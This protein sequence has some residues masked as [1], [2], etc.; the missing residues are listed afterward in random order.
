MH[1]LEMCIRDRGN[2]TD[3]FPVVD[4]QDEVADMINTANEMKETL[5]LVIADCGK[6]LADMARSLIHI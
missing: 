4:T 6:H 3:P 2:L 1:H 5:K